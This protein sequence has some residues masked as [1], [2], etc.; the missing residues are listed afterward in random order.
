MNTLS[1][2]ALGWQ[3]LQYVSRRPNSPASSRRDWAE[4]A[5][6]L[7][8]VYTAVN[9]DQARQR[10]ADFDEKWGKRYTSIAGTWERAWS[11]IWTRDGFV[12]VGPLLSSDKVA[13]YRA[14]PFPYGSAR[15][16]CEG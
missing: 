9:E 15:R 3:S 13:A 10:L 5:R 2:G 4:L 14:P 1:T 12:N 8:P 7:K 6:G 11:E 16:S